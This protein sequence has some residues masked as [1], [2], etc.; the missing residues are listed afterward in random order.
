MSEDCFLKEK[1]LGVMLN[2]LNE[3]LMKFGKLIKEV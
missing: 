1:G 2:K 3:E